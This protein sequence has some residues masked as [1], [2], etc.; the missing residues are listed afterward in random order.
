M[1]AI[2]MTIRMAICVLLIWNKTFRIESCLFGTLFVGYANFLFWYNFGK[3]PFSSYQ[4]ITWAAVTVRMDFFVKKK[5]KKVFQ[6][7]K[8]GPFALLCKSS[9]LIITEMANISQIFYFPI[10]NGLFNLVGCCLH[11]L[12]VG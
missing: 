3:S 5:K 10:N 12:L 8:I 7:R 1:S 4:C 6:H 11:R 9:L 2:P